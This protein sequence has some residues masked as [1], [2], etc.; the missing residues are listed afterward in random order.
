MIVETL[1]GRFIVTADKESNNVIVSADKES[2]LISLL[3]SVE[4]MAGAHGEDQ[5]F[6]ADDIRP[7][8]LFGRTR[9]E[10]TLSRTQLTRYFEYEI[11]NFLDY[12]SLTEMKATK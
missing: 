8:T 2:I 10:T 6:S 9:F 1:P 4:L 11:L 5:S 12:H 7:V 3:D